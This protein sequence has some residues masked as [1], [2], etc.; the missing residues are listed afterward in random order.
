M[1]R[2]RF[3]ATAA[4]LG[5]VLSTGGCSTY[6]EDL[7]PNQQ[8]VSASCS[9]LVI[10]QQKIQ[11]NMNASN[12][13]AALNFFGAVATVFVEA[14]SG[15]DGTATTALAEGSV[16]N[17]GLADSWSEK[18]SLVDRLRAKKGC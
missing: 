12:E 7:M 18:M 3:G 9:Q 17:A 1:K 4:L 15:T 14:D 5:C 8:L 10:E 13:G 11:S 2:V 16:A 6:Y